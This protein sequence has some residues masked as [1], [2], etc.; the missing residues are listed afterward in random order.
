MLPLASIIRSVYKRSIST[1]AIYTQ[2]ASRVHDQ[3]VSEILTP[4]L[5]GRYLLALNLYYQD[6]QNFMN[7]REYELAGQHSIRIAQHD[8]KSSESSGDSLDWKAVSGSTKSDDDISV[9]TIPGPHTLYEP[10]HE[11]RER[12][13]NLLNALNARLDLMTR[14]RN[15]LGCTVCKACIAEIRTI[16]PGP[17]P[18]LSA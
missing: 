9:L 6:V 4:I 14:K 1:I 17:S 3:I 16:S 11:L 10:P 2:A 18:A 5:Y 8:L 12:I 13:F 15:T 7:E